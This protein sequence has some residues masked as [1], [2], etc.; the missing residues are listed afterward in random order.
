MAGMNQLLWVDAQLGLGVRGQS[1][2]GGQPF[3]YMP[4]QAGQH[5]FGPIDPG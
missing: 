4:G 3:G 5:A 2:A 1:V